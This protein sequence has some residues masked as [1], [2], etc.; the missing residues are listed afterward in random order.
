MTGAITGTPTQAGSWLITLS[1]T[2]AG[3]APSTASYTVTIA[4]APDP[5]P[6]ATPD[7]TQD[8]TPTAEPAA[9]PA[10]GEPTD[11]ASTGVDLRVPLATAT[12]LLL[13]GVGLF[14]A[15]RRRKA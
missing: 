2:S 5:T 9:E 1:A 4:A 13:L 6:D 8:P 12:M 10:A 7:P 11:L 14:I 3:T 15:T